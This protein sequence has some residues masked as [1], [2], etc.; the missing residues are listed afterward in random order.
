MQS[1][2]RFAIP[3]NH[4]ALAG[5]FPG[6]PVVPGVV[7]LDH[8]AW[9]IGQCLAGRAPGEWRQVKFQA[10]VLPGQQIETRYTP[11][12]D[13]AAFACLHDGQ[14]VATGVLVFAASAAA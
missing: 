10:P 4:P 1:A 9:L 14:V 2:G 13:Q 11:A 7:L 8:A 3:T 6:R 5:H 12:G